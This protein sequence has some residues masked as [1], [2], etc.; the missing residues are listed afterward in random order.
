M[1]L[2]CVVVS[3]V[4]SI[5]LLPLVELVCQLSVES[6]RLA[7]LLE[8]IGQEELAHLFILM[9]EAF[10]NDQTWDRHEHVSITRRKLLTEVRVFFGGGFDNVAKMDEKFAF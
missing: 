3:E 6:I 7:V 1:L 9:I 2:Q 10:K 4:L 8:Q 5:V